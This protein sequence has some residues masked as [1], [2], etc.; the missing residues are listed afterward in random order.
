MSWLRKPLAVTSLAVAA[1]LVVES[2]F[3]A[4]VALAAEALACLATVLSD[5][6][7]RSADATESTP[8]SGVVNLLANSRIRSLLPCLNDSL[9]DVK[10]NG[11]L[12]VFFA[13]PF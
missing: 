11:K 4:A 9:N 1:M 5:S 3:A 12:P 8:L 6:T 13:A 2:G 7:E 10:L